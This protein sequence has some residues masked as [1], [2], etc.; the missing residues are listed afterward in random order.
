M[1]FWERTNNIRMELHL[2]DALP[3]MSLF[4]IIFL[5]VLFFFSFHGSK[6]FKVF[7]HTYF[8]AL[9]NKV[10]HQK[11]F[12]FL[13]SM[14]AIDFFVWIY[15]LFFFFRFLFVWRFLSILSYFVSVFFFFFFFFFF[16]II[17]LYF[18]HSSVQIVF[19]SVSIFIILLLLLLL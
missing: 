8:Q 9:L 11:T 3:L 2:M 19:V 12:S 5:S 6:L 15:L 16:C 1:I 7:C 14:V 17:R 13:N 18:L 4:L 10:L